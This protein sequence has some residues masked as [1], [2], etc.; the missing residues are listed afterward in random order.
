MSKPPPDA[1]HSYSLRTSTKLGGL[2][3]VTCAPN[4]VPQTSTPLRQLPTASVK[5]TV[6]AT[7]STLARPEFT[8][9]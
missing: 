5:P 1:K 3:P 9:P 8:A 6:L 2:V 7:T 4:V